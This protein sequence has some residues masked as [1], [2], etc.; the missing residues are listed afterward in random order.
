MLA[1]R[2]L[3]VGALQIVAGPKQGGAAAAHGGLRIA[4][5]PGDGAEAVETPGDGGD[6]PP[7]SLHI[8][9]NG[10]EQGAGFVKLTGLPPKSW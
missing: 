4:L 7:L 2:H 3:G 8:R 5:S 6:E 1:E 9:G 10:A